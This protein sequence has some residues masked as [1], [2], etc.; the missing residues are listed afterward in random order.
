MDVKG[1]ERDGDEGEEEESVYDNGRTACL[2]PTELN[3]F[4]LSRQL[5][6]NSR[7][8]QYEKNHRHQHGS[9]VQPHF[10]LFVFLRLSLFSI[11]TYTCTVLLI[12]LY[13]YI[14]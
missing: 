8:Q 1:D 12:C 14:N 10:D 5:K 2:K 13:I 6:Q 9:P 3:R 4:A 11:Y 7:A